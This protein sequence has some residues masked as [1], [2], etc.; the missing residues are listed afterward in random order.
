MNKQVMKCYLEV[1]AP[2]HVGCDEVYEPTGFS[3]DEKKKCLYAFDFMDFIQG[4]NEED[5]S[6]FSNLCQRGTLESIRD[7]YRFMQNREINSKAIDLCEGFIEHY[8]R[9]LKL[10]ESRLQNEL[11][12]FEIART[13]Y[14]AIAQRPYV[15]GSSIK[16]A[17]R[18]AY[19]N[20][21]ARNKP[22]PTPQGNRGAQLLEHTLLSLS[23]ARPPDRI[24][25]DPFRMV[26]VSDFMP[27]GEA[28]TRIVYVVNKKKRP[29]E[30]LARGPYQI[31]EVILPPS[32][33]IGEIVIERPQRPDA[34]SLSLDIK[35]LLVEA[36][37]FYS[38][39]KQREDA[40]L[41]EIGA[42]RAQK[43]T[44]TDTT[45]LRIG[46]HSGAECV[47]IEGHRK[48]RIMQ[49]KKGST[50]KDQATTLWLASET[51][52]PR[53]ADALKSFGWAALGPVNDDMLEA[54]KQI[55]NDYKE[56]CHQATVREPSKNRATP[57]PEPA[58]VVPPSPKSE[59]DETINE[60]WESPVLT[61][62]PGKGELTAS[63]QNKKA[64]AKGKD[65]VPENLRPDLFES[66]KKRCT[67]KSVEVEVYGNAFKIV[68]ISGES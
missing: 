37:R 5:R 16:G 49:G 32:F 65:L 2:I 34:V 35:D 41:G 30:E 59:P 14:S 25:L 56:K 62:N 67:A 53:H 57:S 60:L 15:P 50:T 17:L 33:F 11:N 31:L 46:R 63:F 6:K 21:L 48:I 23:E 8:R 26:K 18:T 29:S 58:P 43:P 39:E 36:S 4:L 40:V 9:V 1:L 22:I 52:K 20:K 12:R 13:S 51:E 38:K 64:F 44:A 66:K 7:I 24:S 28:P 47:T 27:V 10:P 54:L 19:L 3:V 45:L 61:W 42:S 68:R 55:E